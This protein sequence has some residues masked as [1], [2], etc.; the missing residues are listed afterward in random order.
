LKAS[1]KG[2]SSA[3][4]DDSALAMNWSSTSFGGGVVESTGIEEDMIE[5]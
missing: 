5:G 4:V 3:G 1:K 2:W